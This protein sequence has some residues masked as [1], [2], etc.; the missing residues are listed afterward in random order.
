MKIDS[1]YSHKSVKKWIC[2][3]LSTIKTYAGEGIYKEMLEITTSYSRNNQYLNHQTNVSVLVYH[4]CPAIYQYFTLLIQIHTY[5]ILL[6][7]KSQV[8][9]SSADRPV[10]LEF[11]TAGSSKNADAPLTTSWC[12]HVLS[13]P[14]R[15]PMGTGG[16]CC[17]RWEGTQTQKISI[18][19]PADFASLT[20]FKEMCDLQL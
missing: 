2:Q 20:T 5:Q 19:T 10:W 17:L 13:V 3:L 15:K 6:W 18:W 9:Y 14:H 8:S 16:K 4:I 1:F 11:P 12:T 7:G